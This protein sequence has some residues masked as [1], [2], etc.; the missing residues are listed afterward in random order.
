MEKYT[1]RDIVT[2]LES[3]YA[4]TNYALSKLKRCVQLESKNCI[5]INFNLFKK[6][7]GTVSVNYKIEK[8][9]SL[10]KTKSK[11]LT[12]KYGRYDIKSLGAIVDKPPTFHDIITKILDS[13]LVK[14]IDNIYT[15]ESNGYAIVINTNINGVRVYIHDNITG[16][17]LVKYEGSSC[18]VD[19]QN[20]NYIPIDYMTTIEVDDDIIPNQKE[21]I[22]KIK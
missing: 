22:N 2:A 15:F 16:N 8:K 18:L 7:D 3:E 17:N 14:S 9:R 11:N 5:D 21:L 20:N 4:D 6:K 1:L 13:D 10:F 12:M 19:L